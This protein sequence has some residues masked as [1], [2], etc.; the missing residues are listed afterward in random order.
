MEVEIK[1]SLTPSEVKKLKSILQPTLLSI[2]EQSNTFLDTLE[3]QLYAFMTSISYL[4]STRNLLDEKKKKNENE[5][6]K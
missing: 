5:N 6:E 1:L 3:N 2:D 4:L